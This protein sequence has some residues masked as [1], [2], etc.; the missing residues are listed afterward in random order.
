M[1]HELREEIARAGL[2][3]CVFLHGH[4]DRVVEHMGYWDLFVLSSHHEGLPM[5]LLEAMALGVAPVSTA[6]GGIP[7][8]VEDGQNGTLVDAGNA[9]AYADALQRLIEDDGLRRRLGRSAAELVRQKFS[10]ATM[11]EG[12]REVYGFCLGRRRH[13]AAG[14]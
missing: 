11:I 2:G 6:V 14:T 13:V 7:E 1:E 10:V 3:P 5:S 4:D 12:Y 8:V 9:V